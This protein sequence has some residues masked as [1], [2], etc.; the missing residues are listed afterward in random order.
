MQVRSIAA[1]MVLT[2]LLFPVAPAAAQEGAGK[3]KWAVL[4]TVIGI[5]AGGAAG[6]LYYR[7]TDCYQY[8]EWYDNSWAVCVLPGVAMA[9]GGGVAGYFIGRAADKRSKSPETNLQ[10]SAVNPVDVTWGAAPIRL[11]RVPREVGPQD[12]LYRRLFVSDAGV[13]R[14]ARATSPPVYLKAER[15]P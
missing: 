4:G 14:F 3:S 7:Q 6:V 15:R 9:A 5:A 13:S 11:R 1:A 8:D 2:S 10:R 12:R